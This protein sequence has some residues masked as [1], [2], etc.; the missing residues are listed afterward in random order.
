MLA[1][2]NTSNKKY[3][4]WEINN[5]NKA[6]NFW[7]K[8]LS[9]IRGEITSLELGAGS[10]DISMIFSDLNHTNIYTTDLNKINK[11]K[12]IK[13]ENN[14]IKYKKINVLNIDFPNSTFDIIGCKSL[15][16]GISKNDPTKI[17][18]AIKEIRVNKIIVRPIIEKREAR[19]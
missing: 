14:N 6:A 11:Q 9:K 10:G 4:N 18:I 15:L 12:L 2:I 7:L 8:Y 19:G 17:K 5:F 3:F 13:L 16:G 1:Q